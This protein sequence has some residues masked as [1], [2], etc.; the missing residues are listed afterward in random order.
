MTFL[1]VLRIVENENE[2]D[3]ELK[4]KIPK[5]VEKRKLNTPW[6]E[7]KVEE[8]KKSKETTCLMNPSNQNK[9]K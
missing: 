3:E 6:K 9:I 7:T 1:I 4:E 8:K 5:L 2:H